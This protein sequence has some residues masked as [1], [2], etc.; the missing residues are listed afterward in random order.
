MIHG[1]GHA[2]RSIAVALLVWMPEGGL[3]A[4]PSEGWHD[5]FA[6]AVAQASGGHILVLFTGLEWE[7]WSRREGTALLADPEFVAALSAEFAMVHIDLPRQPRDGPGISEE[8]ESRYR[9]AREFRVSGIPSAYLC[10]TDGLPY[11][12]LEVDALSAA[13]RA[14]RVCALRDAHLAAAREVDAR[15]GPERARALEAWL[16]MIPEPLRGSH[17]D[18][19]EAIIEA[20]PGDRTGLRMKYRMELLL[21]EAR[22]LRYRGSLDASEA[23][24]LELIDELPAHGTRAQNLCY[25]LGDVYF[26]RKDYDRLLAVLDRALAA[27]PE[28][29]RVPVIEEM[30]GVF[31]RQWIY[32]RWKPERMREVNYDCARIALD[33]GAAEELLEVIDAAR[34]EAPGSRRNG[35]LDQMKEEFHDLCP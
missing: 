12:W 32:Q 1:R 24:Y 7:D 27:A 30:F 6:A 34:E 22:E 8:E 9:V 29:P 26:Q 3:V 13:D 31:T 14:A 35:V 16:Q 20:D 18:K 10:T 19:M 33:P 15:Q 2:W 17:R 5:D 4:S 11:A 23:R 28:G 21:P 25:E